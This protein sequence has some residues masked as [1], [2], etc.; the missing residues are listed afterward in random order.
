MI[1]SFETG[2]AHKEKM[3]LKNPGN[4]QKCWFSGCILYFNVVTKLAICTDKQ[5]CAEGTQ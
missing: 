1:R 2:N 5:Y 4:T 3:A